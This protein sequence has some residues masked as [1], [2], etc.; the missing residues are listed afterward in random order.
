VT[1]NL[2]ETLAAG[3]SASL[4]ILI[5]G[6][7]I[8]TGDASINGRIVYPNTSIRIGSQTGTVGQM[9]NAIAIGTRAG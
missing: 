4:D 6:N 9:S 1:E 7:T 3:N 2:Q 5:P 8:E